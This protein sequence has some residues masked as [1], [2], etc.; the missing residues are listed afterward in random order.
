M[1]LAVEESG[2][3]ALAARDSVTRERKAASEKYIMIIFV[4]NI[5]LALHYD[6]LSK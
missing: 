2:D 5:F 3:A 6:F 1:G 4:F